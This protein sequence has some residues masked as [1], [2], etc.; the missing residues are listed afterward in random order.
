MNTNSENIHQLLEKLELLLNRQEDFSKEVN[1]LKQEILKL[2]ASELKKEETANIEKET[3]EVIKTEETVEETVE[4]KKTP[5]EPRPKKEPVPQPKAL[6]S[7]KLRRDRQHSIIGGVCAGLADYFGIYRALVRFVFI[8]LS[9]IFCIGVLLY[10]ILWI[11]TPRT[12]VSSNARAIPPKPKEIEPLVVKETAAISQPQQNE[13]PVVQ[14]KIEPLPLEIVE[15]LVIKEAAPS[16]KPLEANPTVL[17]KKSKFSRP[18]SKLSLE[19]FIGENLANKIGIIIIIIGVAIGVK[20][21][22]EHDLLTPLMRIILGYLVGLGLLGFGIKLKKK[23][24][25][26][27]AVLVSGAI[28]ILYITTFLGYE[29]YQLF[30]ITLAFFLMLV[31]TAFSI[32]AAINYNKQV[33]AFIGLV[34]AYGVPFL[35]SSNSGNVLFLFS[36]MTIIN[37]GILIIAIKKYWKP[38]Y[39]FAFLLSWLIFGTWVSDGYVQNLH[40]TLALVVALVFFI[41]FY[42]T[43]LAFKLVRKEKFNIADVLP[44]LAN[45]FIYYGVGYHILDNH[46]LGSQLLGA[47]TLF[48]GVLHFIVSVF[49]YKQKPI[50]KNLFYLAISLAIVFVTITVPVQL[51]GNMV[52]LIWGVQAAVLFWIGRTKS[53]SMYEY[54][55]YPMMVL[56]TLSLYQDWIPVF[57][58]PNGDAHTT[59]TAVLNAR[60]LT[61]LIFIAAFGFI[62]KINT[63]KS[64]TSPLTPDMA[65]VVSIIVPTIFLSTL[66]LSLRL[67]LVIY[68]EN[69]FMDSKL[70]IGEYDSIFNYDLLKFK[71]IWVILYSMLFVSVLSFI[72][73]K[74]LKNILLGRITLALLALALLTFMIQGLNNLSEL[75]DSYLSQTNAE[76][77]LIDSFHIWFR[78]VAYPFVALV[79]FA[80]YK[81][82]RQEFMEVKLMKIFQLCFSIAVFWILSSELTHWLDILDATQWYKLGLSILSIVQASVLFWIGRTKSDRM[83]EYIAYPMM[84]LATLIFYQDWEPLFNPYNTDTYTAIT[85]VLNVRFIA[86]LIFIAAFGFIYKINT[87]TSYT[88]PLNPDVAK[89]V[90]FLVP[91][92]FLCTLYLSL[93]LELVS[94]WQNLFQGSKRT[95]GVSDTLFNYDL[96]KFKAIWVILYS[97]LFVSVL[98]FINIKKLKKKLLGRITLA[99]LVLVLL[100][101]MIQGLYNLSELRDSYLSQ[102]NA[103][104]YLIDS[105][106]IWFR[107]VAYPFV[108][109]VLFAAYK[110]IHQQFMEVKLLKTF[111]LC[112]SLSVFWMISSELIHWLDLLDFAESYKLSL[113][114]LWGVYS[115]SLISIG[116]WKKKQHFRIVAIVI[117]LGTLI[118]LFFYDLAHLNTISK[119]IVLL[120]LGVLLLIISFLYNKFK[121]SITEDPEN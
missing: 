61:S 4:D 19:K 17:K 2:K 55:A 93:R 115:L 114:I 57:N 75:R 117:F 44:L 80:A 54:I 98:S 72:N 89:V 1:D 14:E 58:Y 65:K 10:L 33:I 118:K 88:T 37:I 106:H 26:F 105:F 103:E 97:M 24:K 15:P 84:I 121:A 60:F 45:S 100:T 85:V 110:Y 9:V 116:I 5:A 47:F 50:N 31:F 29:L 87:N 74:K 59:L 104:Y 18:K 8:F 71:N 77:Y 48:N 3:I 32:V 96:L 101:F 91:T 78:Y 70:P 41:I 6:P 108:A 34:G 107:Y 83:Y 12:I 76:Y 16:P 53:I 95:L 23:Y 22:I 35:L 52:T 49:L 90:V 79:L 86:S 68:C 38:L 102:T 111:Q 51:D 21:S 99:L 46:E 56:A 64:Y 13:P 30:P 42:L 20:Y 40:Y 7:H 36:Y 119:S 39:L 43:F 11:F 25:D 82:I 67:E 94:Y 66:Y 73:I 62:Y 28:A 81:Y 92:I 112:L 109:L 27:S 63:S 120:S 113:S 69:L